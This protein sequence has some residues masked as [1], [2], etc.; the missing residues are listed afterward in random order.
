MEKKP[1]I[2]KA[3]VNLVIDALLLLVMAAML[4]IG[5][6]IK[7]ILITGE[8][9]TIR[10]GANFRQTIFGM[11]RHD[12]GAIHL[13][14]GYAMAGL[15]LLH[16]ILHWKSIVAMFRNFIRNTAA[17]I[18][19]LV[20]LVIASLILVLTPFV[21]KPQV[22]LQRKHLGRTNDKIG[23]MAV[24][25][26]RNNVPVENK[27]NN[28]ENGD[29][30]GR[31]SYKSMDL[32]IKGYMTIADVCGEYKISEKYLIEKLKIPEGTDGNTRLRELKDRYGIRMG[33]IKEIIVNKNSSRNE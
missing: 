15:L 11:D 28:G 20:F 26:Y 17:R 27:Q 18:S 33:K 9:K 30:H 4:G 22:D 13:Y 19:V 3:K 25:D 1:I 12:W 5:L 2:N 24:Q 16:I 32:D 23:D 8:E 7:Y 14:I 29:G 6:M 21:L 10:Y 31:R